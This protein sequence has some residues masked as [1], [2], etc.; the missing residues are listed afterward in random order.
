MLTLVEAVNQQ[1][2]MVSL[3]LSNESSGIILRGINGLDPVDADLI[4]TAFGGRDGQQPQSARR[5]S[6]NIVIMVDLDPR[7]GG[8]SA[9]DLRQ[10][11]YPVF[12]PK[13]TV[14]LRFYLSTGL[15]VTIKG[16]VESLNTPLFV[17]T[18]RA[19][20]SIICD[21]PD[22][23]DVQ[24]RE[25]NYEAYNSHVDHDVVYEGTV[26]T[27]MEFTVYVNGSTTINSIFFRQTTPSGRYKILEF[28]APLTGLD[29]VIINTTPGQK[30]AV[31]KRSGIETSIL[32][33]IS[34]QSEWPLLEPGLNKIS[35]MVPA[36]AQQ[37]GY[38]HKHFDRHGGL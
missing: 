38:T 17:K 20:I 14:D 37:S 13:T 35:V 1:G 3:P 6:R 12:M 31:R 9:Q 19:A 18:P 8:G 16:Q 7:Y 2:V 24:E 5:G 22:F 30:S 29:Q 28:N 36:P 33:G 25:Y 27:G 15:E 4:S 23:H 10:I 32:Y 21:D 34:P 26:P 11:L